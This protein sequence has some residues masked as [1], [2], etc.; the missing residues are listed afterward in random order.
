MQVRP[1][2]PRMSI[3][4]ALG[5]RLSPRH[6]ALASRRALPYVRWFGL[7]LAPILPVFIYTDGRIA[8]TYE[9]HTEWL[10][11]SMAAGLAVCSL[12]T[13]LK[14]PVISASS[15]LFAVAC[16]IVLGQTANCYF[17]RDH[18][19][20]IY[21]VI[22]VLMGASLF[23]YYAP[24]KFILLALTTLGLYLGILS[25]GLG[26]SLTESAPMA[27]VAPLFGCVFGSA[28]FAIGTWERNLREW[29]YLET[30]EEQRA[31]L[32]EN[33]RLFRKELARAEQVQRRLLPPTRL[34]DNYIQI[35]FT[36]VPAN[37]VGGDLLDVI[38]LEDGIYA[39]LIADVSGHGIASALIS[40]M[41]KM[42][43]YALD[44]QILYRPAALLQRLDLLLAQSLHR[45][46]ITAVYGILNIRDMTFE[47]ASAGH[48]P[49]IVVRR[50]SPEIIH[51]G[52]VGRALGV[53]EN[54]TYTSHC[55][56]LKQDDTIF[57]FTDG[58]F[59]I[60]DRAEE[61]YTLERFRGLVHSTKGIPFEH[62]I[63]HVL[64]SL[65]RMIP[66]EP[67]DDVTLLACKINLTPP[68]GSG[69]AIAVSSEPSKNVVA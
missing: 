18:D 13:F 14:R 17:L 65:R 33:E 2:I 35:D 8:G 62:V 47:F 5:F 46:F 30:L 55:I 66:D 54:N 31:L 19:A 38:P 39:L 21:T 28:V 16:I 26:L 37:N 23:T 10:R 15:L 44:R 57:L 64:T 24:W 12:L 27:H 41:L 69:N 4:L 3:P 11:L 61:V 42:S 22:F 67:Q 53:F 45:E 68:T 32:A 43:V 6:K 34:S 7:L 51:T 9:P 48:E 20:A 56:P 58:C 29:S 52:T 63:E 50:E 40:S 1:E 36:Y 49:P 25:W 59:D 60:L